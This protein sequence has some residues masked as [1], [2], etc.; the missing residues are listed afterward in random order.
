MKKVFKITG[1]VTI[2]LVLVCNLQYALFSGNMMNTPNKAFADYY[3]GGV[4]YCGTSPSNNVTGYWS[5]VYFGDPDHPEYNNWLDV[6]TEGYWLFTRDSDATDCG[7]EMVYPPGDPFYT[8]NFCGAGTGPLATGPD[9]CYSTP[10]QW[11]N[12]TTCYS[13]GYGPY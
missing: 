3:S 10:V 9:Y 4:H 6:D 1:I 8:G 12:F 7:P 2:V 11:P 5:Y 13:G